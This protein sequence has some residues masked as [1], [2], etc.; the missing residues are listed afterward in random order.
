M[1]PPSIAQHRVDNPSNRSA[2]VAR[3]VSVRHRRQPSPGPDIAGLNSGDERVDDVIGERL[4]EIAKRQRH[5]QIYRD[6]DPNLPRQ[7]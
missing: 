1:Q 7:R 5:D 4:D 6:N 2:L 3:R